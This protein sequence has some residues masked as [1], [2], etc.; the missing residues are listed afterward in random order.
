MGK[1]VSDAVLDGMLDII[2]ASDEIAACLGEPLTYYEAKDPVVWS[3][4]QTAV[5]GDICKPTVRNGYNYECTTG[6]AVGGTEPSWGTTPGGT[7]NDNVAVWTCRLARNAANHTL[8]G[9]DFSNS[10]GDADGRKV[11]IAQQADVSI[12]T[13]KVDADHVALLNDTAKELTIVTTCT[14]QTL[15]QG[16]TVTFPAFD[17]EV[18][19]P[20]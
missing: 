5:V 1:K 13:T 4:P 20:T 12:H 2:G 14:A 8:T 10:D 16:N 7:T 19:D 15:T 9:G 3:Q 17:D 18:A 11:T 6:G